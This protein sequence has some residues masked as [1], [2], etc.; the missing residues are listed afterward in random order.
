MTSAFPSPVVYAI[1]L[2]EFPNEIPM[3]KVSAGDAPLSSAL[4][5]S[6]I[7]VLFFSFNVKAG[8]RV[9]ATFCVFAR[10]D[11]AAN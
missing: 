7:Q 2:L 8:E 1:E 5:V 10:F 9:T 3:A 11:G 6:V 4:I